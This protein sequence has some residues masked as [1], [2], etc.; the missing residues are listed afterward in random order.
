MRRN[1]LTGI[2]LKVAKLCN[3]T[4]VYCGYNIWDMTTS[5]SLGTDHILPYSMGGKNKLNNLVCCCSLCNSL[6]SNTLFQSF[7]DKKRFIKLR[8]KKRNKGEYKF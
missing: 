1:G 5:R 8:L 7:K 6:L 2:H 4:C 3:Y